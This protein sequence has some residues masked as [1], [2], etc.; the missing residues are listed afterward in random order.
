MRKPERRRERGTPRARCVF[1]SERVARGTRLDID[2]QN[3]T[4]F[5]LSS[6]LF[7]SFPRN[8]TIECAAARQNKTS[9][10]TTVDQVLAPFFFYLFHAELSIR[11]SK[12]TRIPRGST[13]A[14]ATS[15]RDTRE[16]K[17]DSV[18]L[19]HT[20]CGWQRLWVIRFLFCHIPGASLRRACCRCAK[21]IFRIPLLLGLLWW[22]RVTSCGVVRG[23]GRS[24]AKKWIMSV[25]A[26]AAPREIIIALLLLLASRGRPRGCARRTFDRSC[27]LSGISLVLWRNLLCG[28]GECTLEESGRKQY[29]AGVNYF[30][31]VDSMSLGK[32]QYL[33]TDAVQVKVTGQRGWYF[34]FH[35]N[36]VYLMTT[37][38]YDDLLM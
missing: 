22:A 38:Q 12:C 21:V 32:Y 26:A 5:S 2:E 15:P 33:D 3:C 4:A 25:A 27:G 34:R 23:R 17:K 24:G 31:G 13:C 30:V 9:P 18:K 16:G 19:T 29:L 1:E 20:A 8:R 35:L 37:S 36:F 14:H 7:L 28:L 11:A 6:S 10:H